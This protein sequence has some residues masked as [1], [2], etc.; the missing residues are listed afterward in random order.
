M[1]KLLAFLFLLPLVA[2]GQANLDI[3]IRQYNEG[4]GWTDKLVTITPGYYLAFDSNGKPITAA[5]GGGGSSYTFTS[6]LVDTSGTV[7]IND[8]AADGSTKG[9]ASFTAA[10][11]DAT[12]GNV[13]IDYTNG[14]AATGSVKG[15]LTAADWTTFN[16]KQSALTF[17]SPLSNTTGTISIANAA[18][19]GSTKG[20]A[21]FTAADFDATTGNIAIDYTNGQAASGS[22]KGFLA[23]A[24]WTTFNNKA[25]LSQNNNWTGQH[26]HTLIPSITSTGASASA[27]MVQGTSY[28]YTL[29]ADLTA[30]SFTGTAANGRIF[31]TLLGC[32]GT[33]S[34][35]FPAAKRIGS[36]DS[37]TT[38]LTPGAGNH[39]VMFEYI[40]STWYYT[41]S[42]VGLVS[43]TSGISGVLPIANGGTNGATASA[44]FDNLQGA[45]TTVAS[46]TT[47][48]LGAVAS[49]KVSITGTTT[50][51]GFGTKTAGVVRE[52][53]FTGILTLTHNATSL[54]LPGGANI[55]TA[56]GDRFRAYSLGSGNWVVTS[57]VTA[58]AASVGGKGYVLQLGGYA[59]SSPA[60]ATVYAGGPMWGGDS[61]S[62]T[63]GRYIARVPKAGTIKVTQ[64]D[65]YASTAGSNEA[66]TMNISVNG[67]LTSIGSVSLSTNARAWS[68]TGQ[69]IAVS[70]GDTIEFN[71]TTPT[72]ATNPASLR[73]W[74]HVYIE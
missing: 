53:R 13:S 65:S 27:A 24:D 6:P 66:W 51:T 29:T 59:I 14:Q 49:D 70:V 37:T 40:G 16:A 8:A 64:I 44:G 41:D 12:T 19:D 15:F 33:H 22:T 42:V 74:G 50:I 5:G 32:D 18:A 36:A 9:A 11:F 62:A 3:I 52:G 60:D 54:I 23:S 1:K 2:F 68:A 39:M 10:D 30:T 35:T 69:S 7:T 55:T 21:S 61:P 25:G 20:A 17:S 73:V 28:T 4:R 67:S 58:A 43:L 63:T 46:A 47:T 48:D 56:A 72:W 57:Y 71:T 34:F 45:E 31:V 26:S 38:S